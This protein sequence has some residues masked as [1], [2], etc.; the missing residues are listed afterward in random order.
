LTLIGTLYRYQRAAMAHDKSQYIARQLA[1]LRT[2]SHVAD[3][4]CSLDDMRQRCAEQKRKSLHQ[5]KGKQAGQTSKMPVTM[6]GK[7]ATDR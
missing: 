3:M 7:P 6:T 2:F 1:S 5:G 4:D